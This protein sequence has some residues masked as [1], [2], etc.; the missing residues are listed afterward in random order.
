MLTLTE[1]ILV[2]QKLSEYHTG[3]RAWSRSVLERLPIELC[4]EDFVFDNEMLAQSI[5]RASGL[6]R[7]PA[8]PN[9]FRKRLRSTFGAAWSMDLAS[10]GPPLNSGCIGGA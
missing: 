10:C 9:T 4:S 1:N 5:T 2:G 8:R 3:Y 7:F 6:A